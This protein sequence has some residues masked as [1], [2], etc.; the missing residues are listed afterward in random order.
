VDKVSLVFAGRVFD[1]ARPERRAGAGV[2]IHAPGGLGVFIIVKL[3]DMTGVDCSDPSEDGKSGRSGMSGIS[4]GGEGVLSIIFEVLDASRGGV[5]RERAGSLMMI[6]GEPA[7]GEPFFGEPLGGDPPL[8]NGNEASRNGDSSFKPETR[9]EGSKG[10][11][12]GRGVLLMGESMG[13]PRRSLDGRQLTT[14]SDN[15]KRG[16]ILW[17]TS[18]GAKLRGGNKV[19]TLTRG[20]IAPFA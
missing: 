20:G 4:V 19:W 13:T 15:I 12:P 9:G 1:R 11:G 14:F 5:A 3:L 18:S 6:G 7:S 2:C 10:N 8:A 17:R 16:H